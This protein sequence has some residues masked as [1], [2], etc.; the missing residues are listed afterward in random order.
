MTTS[1]QRLASKCGSPC[2]KHLALSLCCPVV[3]V[4]PCFVQK[5][6]PF[7]SHGHWASDFWLSEVHFRLVSLFERGLTLQ[8]LREAHQL[9]R[10]LSRKL[11]GLA[12]SLRSGS[13]QLSGRASEGSGGSEAVRIPGLVLKLLQLGEIQRLCGSRRSTRAFTSPL[14]KWK[15]SSPPCRKFGA[16]LAARRKSPTKS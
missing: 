12:D 8:W 7:T 9:P 15:I 1:K 2:P 4:F 6:V 10:V 14:R 13:E 16:Q 11:A 3:P 5:K